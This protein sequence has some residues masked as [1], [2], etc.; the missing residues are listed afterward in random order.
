MFRRPVLEGSGATRGFPVDSLP[1]QF[2]AE[3]NRLRFFREYFKPSLA[4]ACA[5]YPEAKIDITERG[6]TLHPSR[7]PIAKIA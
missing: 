3:V 6:I 5:V 7:P 2:G 4:I 1:A